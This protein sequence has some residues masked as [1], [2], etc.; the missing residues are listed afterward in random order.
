MAV[1]LFDLE[2]TLVQSIENDKEAILE[3]RIKTRE[4][5]LELRVP[6]NELKDVTT[7]TLMRNRALQYVRKHFNEREAERFHLEMDRFLKRYELSWADQS[8][9]FPDT[10][11]ALNRLRELG[12]RMGI[13]TNTSREAADRI[14]S[15]HGI[16]NF[17][18]VIITREDVKELK[19]DPEG[20]L[21]AL[22]KL[23]AQDFF[24][25]GDLVHD[26]KATER[27]GGKCIIVNRNP[28]KRLE[29]QA[30]YVVKSL[31]DISGLIQSLV[32]GND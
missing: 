5:L 10:L 19:P 31:M 7:S 17:F 9:I 27:A 18:E 20:I 32:T 12:Y 29:F 22:K 24:F 3:F 14:L 30:D 15:M 28:L 26:S 8:E 23:N 6:L 25:V 2:G 1:V 4:K 21:L 13:I 11:P 16:A